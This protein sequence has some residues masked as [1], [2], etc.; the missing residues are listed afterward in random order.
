MASKSILITGCS[1]EGIGDGLAREFKSRGLR[2]FA[3][4]RDPAK[5]AHLHD[6]G[7]TVLILD[8][9]DSESIATAAATVRQATEGRGLDILINNA[10]VNHYMPFADCAVDDIRRVFETNV[11]GVFAVNPGILAASHR[12]K[13]DSREHRI[14]E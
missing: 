12:G 4:G 5:L 8:V 11:I 3:A 13:G 6:L 9:T 10:G 2:V 1:K 7:I 14:R